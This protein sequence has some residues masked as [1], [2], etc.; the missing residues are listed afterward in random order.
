[1]TK[2]KHK[3]VA[4][5]KQHGHHQKRTT[6]FMKVYK[7]FIPMLSILALIGIFTSSYSAW[8]LTRTNSTSVQS[9]QVLAYATDITHVG[10]LQSTNVRRTQA[11]VS[12]LTINNQ[13]NQAAQAKASDMA[14]RNYWAH[15]N[16]DGVQP[17]VF[18]ANAGYSYLR[19]GENLACGFSDN[20]TVITGWYNSPTHRDNMLEAEFTEVGFGIINAPNYNCGEFAAT[21]QT[22]VVAMYGTPANNANSSSPTPQSNNNQSPVNQEQPVNQGTPVHNSINKATPNNSSSTSQKSVAEISKHNATLTIVNK[23]NLPVSGVKVSIRSLSLSEVSNASGMVVFKELTT[24]KYIVSME[25]AGAKTEV[26]LD[27]NEQPAEFSQTLTA[28]ELTSNQIV[29]DSDDK[30]PTASP[31]KVSRLNA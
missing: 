12:N 14:M 23:D 6:H 26:A 18:I 31:K 13:L 27:L 29:L 15:V 10:L 11:G 4:H 2:N 30:L 25:V 22:I 5:N 28:P 19:A 8:N 20:N 3:L 9:R 1:M 17:W 7:P 16:P 24:D 21:Q